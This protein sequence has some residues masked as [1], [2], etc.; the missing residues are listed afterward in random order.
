MTA[1][2]DMETKAFQDKLAEIKRLDYLP[3]GLADLVAGVREIQLSAEKQVQIELP[4]KEALAPA[5]MR[6][7]GAPLLQR[8]KLPFDMDF[9]SRVFSQLVDLLKEQTGP[10]AEAAKTLETEINNGTVDLETLFIRYLDGDQEFFTKAAERT[11][12][13][14]MLLNFL[15]HSSLAPSLAAASRQLAKQ[16]L[17]SLNGAWPHGHCPVCGSLP[18]IS[19]L[20]GKE[21]VRH[22]TCSLCSHTYRSKRIG[23]CFCGES[24]FE[25]L[26]FFHSEEEPGFRVDVCHTCNHYIKTTDFRQLDRKAYPLLDDLASLP[27]DILAGQKGFQRATTSGWGF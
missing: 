1:E 8:V 17:A 15:A 19:D 6:S 13:A 9:S 25:K 2:T 24:D 14:P 12:Q 5:D 22:H 7:Q 21:G 11:P 27:L 20:R 18:L 23:C 4:G 3:A 16:H 26:A 10:L